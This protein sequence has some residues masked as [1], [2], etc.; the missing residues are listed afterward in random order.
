MTITAWALTTG[1][2]GMRTQARGL[3]QAVAD[4]VVEKT[5]PSR[6]RQLS[7]R[8]APADRL[9]LPWPDLL[10]TCGRRSVA[11]SIALRKESGGRTVTVHVQD[12]RGRPR[13]FDLVIAMAHDRIPAGGNVMKIATALHDL[14]PENLADAGRLWAARFRTLGRPL[15]GVV[16]GGD[17][18]GRAFTLRDGARLLS[19]LKRLRDQGGANLAI[20]PSRRTPA[21]VRALFAEAFADDP[22]VFLW[23]LKGDNPYRAI[24]ALSDRLIVTSDSVSMVSEA[25]STPHPVEVFD[26][27]FPRHVSFVQRLVDQG[28]IR[29]FEGEPEPPRTTGP[30]NATDQAACAVRALLQARTG[31]VG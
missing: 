15:A 16:I 28:L 11:R 29:R 19:R 18:R 7:G 21:A 10:I 27:G 9:S 26:L 12:P 13:A 5:V 17:L 8:V 6:W 24:L 31:V 20:T 2:T 14:T 1:E 4:V 30:I 25:L 22:R 3:A 23:N